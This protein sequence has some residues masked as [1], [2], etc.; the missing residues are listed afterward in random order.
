M[1]INVFMSVG[2]IHLHDITTIIGVASVCGY[3][4][5]SKRKKIHA[6]T[7]NRT[8]VVCFRRILPS[9]VN[10]LGYLRAR[11]TTTLS[12]HPSMEAELASHTPRKINDI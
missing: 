7:G 5:F 9:R 10:A 1:L 6:D 4:T 8:N 2:R 12:Q 11:Q 3:K